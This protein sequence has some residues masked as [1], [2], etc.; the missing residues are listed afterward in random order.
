MLLAY[1]RMQT[2]P[3]L[4][5]DH[6]M[7]LPWFLNHHGWGFLAGCW[8]KWTAQRT[9]LR[10]IPFCD[11]YFLQDHPKP[12]YTTPGKN[13][14]TLWHPKSSQ[15]SSNL[16]H[17]LPLLLPA[18]PDQQDDDSARGSHTD[19]FPG[20][21]WPGRV[22]MNFPGKP[23]RKKRWSQFRDIFGELCDFKQSTSNLFLA[24]QLRLSSVSPKVGMLFSILAVFFVVDMLGIVGLWG[25]RNDS[26]WRTLLIPR[27][28]HR[29]RNF[30]LRGAGSQQVSATSPSWITWNPLPMGPMGSGR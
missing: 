1:Y 22:A 3:W 30:T 18:M 19:D 8:Q 16:F 10:P 15:H 26:G 29:K 5:K 23:K 4:S 14:H 20:R 9:S 21:I 6:P 13:I 2:M 11:F 28:V 7:I 17:W 12:N 27:Q 25:C 24:P